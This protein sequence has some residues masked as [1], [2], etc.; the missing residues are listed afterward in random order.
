MRHWSKLKF[1]T[2]YYNISSSQLHR[3]NFL[4]TGITLEQNQDPHKVSCFWLE[5]MDVSNGVLSKQ[6]VKLL[7]NPAARL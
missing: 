1:L 4:L 6:I 5:E 2:C 7:R 3:E